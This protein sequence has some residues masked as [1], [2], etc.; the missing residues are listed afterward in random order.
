VK[1]EDVMA[2]ESVRIIEV[3]GRPAMKKEGSKYIVY[4][5]VEL[6]VGTQ[7][8]P[9]YSEGK[10][11]T[12]QAAYGTAVHCLQDELRERLAACVQAAVQAANTV[13]DTAFKLNLKLDEEPQP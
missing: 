12:L 1:L 5:T 8:V 3:K 6:A 9:V 10:G 11:D 7:G 2:L 4:I 13:R